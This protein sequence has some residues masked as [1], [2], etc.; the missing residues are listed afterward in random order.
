MGIRLLR[1]TRRR[2]RDRALQPRLSRRW[3]TRVR[4]RRVHVGFALVSLAGAPTR[5][6]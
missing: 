2:Q 5:G 6:G 1:K 3:C 4:G